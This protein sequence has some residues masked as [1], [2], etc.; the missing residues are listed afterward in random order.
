MPE[1]LKYYWLVLRGLQVSYLNCFSIEMNFIFVDFIRR[2]A[3]KQSLKF[4][5]L[6]IK[7]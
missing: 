6:Y 2:I 4:E 7:L 1:C 5:G 3:H